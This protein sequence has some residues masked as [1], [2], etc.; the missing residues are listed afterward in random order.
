MGMFKDLWEFD[1]SVAV[2]AH[3][4]GHLHHIPW[5]SF[6]TGNIYLPNNV[7]YSP[8]LLVS[9]L[10]EISKIIYHNSLA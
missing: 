1:T 6:T 2:H 4:L 10:V 7:T 3:V 9:S 8:A 5:S